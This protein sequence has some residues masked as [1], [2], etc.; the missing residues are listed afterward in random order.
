MPFDFKAY[1]QKCNGLTLEEL[2]REW[3]HYTRLISGAAT[4]A[5]V[6][7]M[8]IPLTLGVSTIGVAMAAPAIHNA[9][10]KREIIEKHLN[11]LNATH[12][13]R[14]R[15]V[16]GSMAVSGTIGVVTLG[17]GSMGA[18]AVAT[19]GAEHGIQSIVQNELAIK[20]VTHAAL[21]GAGMAVEH[22][23][24]G[25][26]K[27]KDA[28]KAFQKAG[29]FQA[30]QDAKAAEAG[31]A[32][33]P[34]NNQAYPY[35][36]GSSSSQAMPMPPPPY[37]APTPGITTPQH[38]GPPAYAPNPN[39][40]GHPQDLKVP[41]AQTPVPQHPQPYMMPNVNTQQPVPQTYP[42]PQQQAI[43]NQVPAQPTGIPSATAVPT[44]VLS[45]PQ[46][47]AVGYSPNV[48]S[49]SREGIQSSMTPQP[50]PHQQQPSYFPPTS[51][52]PTYNTPTSSQPYDM[53]AMN[54]AL[55]AQAPLPTPPYQQPQA[56]PPQPQQFSGA[57]LPTPAQEY[58]PAYQC[59]PATPG[60]PNQTAQATTGYPP[61]VLAPV[62]TP[63]PPSTTPVPSAATPN[64]AQMS[65]G[66]AA[67]HAT[68]PQ[69]PAA[70]GFQPHY[71]QYTSPQHTGSY[72]PTQVPPPPPPSDP[73]RRDSVMGVPQQSYAPH[74]PYNPQE[75]ASPSQHQHQQPCTY[76]PNAAVSAPAQPSQF[77]QTPVQYHVSPP[78]QPSAATNVTQ[79]QQQVNGG[80]QPAPLPVGQAQQQYAP[81]VHYQS[82]TPAPYLVMN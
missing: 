21:D 51:T 66:Y 72:A 20:V 35:A 75:Y 73:H 32:P 56:Q 54:A 52:I 39:P 26:L 71:Q 44:H 50:Q 3:E 64:P 46:T 77:A 23:H 11:K 8:A 1:D 37:T 33:Q 29:V 40:T 82:A 41:L 9:R 70:Q 38:L 62:P 49:Q 53:S 60:F 45:P 34:Y 79:Y 18:D 68:G 22:A 36:A 25:H 7:G 13:T 24:T 30:V 63:Q 2:Q 67:Q 61:P 12:H 17:V 16:L 5:A 15:D 28:F 80:Y 19:A 58:T 48:V 43:P 78:S 4:S 69:Q 10:K 31:Y 76:T 42:Y 27:K 6:S 65:M 81:G 47:P 74:R 14:K 55:P 59:P 57:P